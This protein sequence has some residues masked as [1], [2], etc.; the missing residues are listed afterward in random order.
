MALGRESRHFTLRTAVR[1]SCAVVAAAV[2]AGSACSDAEPE[3]RNGGP[4]SARVAAYV[5]D[6]PADAEKPALR[7][8]MV[9][10][11]VVSVRSEEGA[12]VDLGRRAE[13]RTSLQD[14]SGAVLAAETTD[15]PPGTY[16]R[17][18]ATLC[19]AGVRLEPGTR[20]AGR[21]LDEERSIHVT[22]TGD[23]V[24]ERPVPPVRVGPDTDLHLSLDLRSS[25]WVTDEAVRTGAA[26]IPRLEES[27]RI[28]VRQS[29]A[30]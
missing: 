26:S 22:E 4:A 27:A 9:A 7:G 11:Y 6:R 18:R 30:G 10:S 21:T 1:R 17:V 23:V 14:A 25:E 16:V 2:A 8:E 13:L 19:H 12:W 15:L 24:I 28:L 29:P 20:V 5:V 3:A